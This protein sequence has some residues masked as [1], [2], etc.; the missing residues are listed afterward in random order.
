MG[1]SEGLTM[2]KRTEKLWK[3]S[4]T[5]LIADCSCKTKDG[6]RTTKFILNEHSVSK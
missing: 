6:V 4:R 1:G 2:E 5:F 3:Y